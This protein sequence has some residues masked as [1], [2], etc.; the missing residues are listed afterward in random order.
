MSLIVFFFQ[1]ENRY[2]DEWREEQT[3]YSQRTNF[4]LGKI[5]LFADRYSEHIGHGARLERFVNNFTPRYN[6]NC[7]YDARF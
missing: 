1:R 2:I 4:R 3:F 6:T 5:R 7:T